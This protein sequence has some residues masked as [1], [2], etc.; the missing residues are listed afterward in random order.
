MGTLEVP[1]WD[2]AGWGPAGLSVGP[3]CKGPCAVGGEGVITEICQ[4][5]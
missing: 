5:G 1:G 4:G 2:L 3:V